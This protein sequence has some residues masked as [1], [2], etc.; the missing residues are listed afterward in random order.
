MSE[1][2]RD[3]EEISKT[4]IKMYDKMKEDQEVK[5]KTSAI[6]KLIVYKYFNPDVEIWWDTR[7]GKFEYGAGEAPGK[8]D[9]RMT[10][11][12]DDAHR[13]WSNKLNAVMAI[14]RKKIKVEGAITDLLKLTS[15]QK[16]FAEAYNQALTEMGKQ[17]IILK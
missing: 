13:A 2:W 1:F 8:F 9:V 10:L 12:A 17:D 3:A 5:K 6:N 7:E 11:S 4:V 14:T 16:K 15:L